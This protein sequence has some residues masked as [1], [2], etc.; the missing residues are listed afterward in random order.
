MA[1]STASSC[2]GSPAEHLGWGA[3]RAGVLFHKSRETVSLRRMQRQVLFANSRV[4][5]VLQLEFG[6]TT[7]ITTT[8]LCG[9]LETIWISARHHPYQS[10]PS[11]TCR[12]RSEDLVLHAVWAPRINISAL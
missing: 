9:R 4:Q 11:L 6:S 7:R 10:P 5:A 12:F 8:R 1:D 2:A 3:I